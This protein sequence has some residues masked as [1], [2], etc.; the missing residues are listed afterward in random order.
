MLFLR[1]VA[2]KSR[3]D[4]LRHLSEPIRPHNQ[5]A[6]LRARRVLDQRW[7]CRSEENLR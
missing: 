5:A 2:R 6:T 4:S 3:S 1:P 7:F